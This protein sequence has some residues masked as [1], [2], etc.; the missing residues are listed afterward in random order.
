MKKIKSVEQLAIAK[1]VATKLGITIGQ[2]TD[3][4]ETE[5][6]KRTISPSSPQYNPLIR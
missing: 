2:V 1:I 4:I 6:L 3:V 5:W